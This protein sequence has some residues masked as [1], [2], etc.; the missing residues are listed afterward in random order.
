MP[1]QWVSLSCPNCGA[2]LEVYDDMTRFACGFCRTEVIAE[3]RGSTI[4]LKSLADVIQ[5]VQAGTDKTAAELSLRRLPTDLAEAEA[6]LKAVKA[7]HPKLPSTEAKDMGCVF[8][9]L[10]PGL[11]AVIAM[12]VPEGGMWPLLILAV[13]AA[14]WLTV[15]TFS[16]PPHPDVKG[17]MDKHRAVIKEAEQKVQSIKDRIENAKRIADG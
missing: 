11:I 14:V 6:E 2:R 7:A 4:M 15:H 12:K 9:I 5:R 8:G 17:I 3:R 13:I 1:D 16:S 10:L